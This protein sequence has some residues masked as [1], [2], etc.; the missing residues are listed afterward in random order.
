MFEKE[1]N[2][3]NFPWFCEI[4]FDDVTFFGGALPGVYCVP[5]QVFAL[6]IQMFKL[7]LSTGVWCVDVC[8]YRNTEVRCTV[9][10]CT[11]PGINIKSCHF[12]VIFGRFGFFGFIL[13]VHYARSIQMY[14]MKV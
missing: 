5:D 14:L 13:G 3:R 11:Y 9:Q 1:W 12:F 10:K 2:H 8:V 6:G 7:S 4:G